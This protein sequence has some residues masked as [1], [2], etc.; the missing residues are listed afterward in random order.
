MKTQGVHMARTHRYPSYM[1]CV[2]DALS[3]SSQPVSI[4]GL[5]AAV[6][7]QRPLG[8]GAH[9]AVK[10]AIHQLFQVIPVGA[11]RY[12]WLSHLLNGAVI[13]HTLAH[14][15][16]LRGFILLDE[17]EHTALFPQFFQ[18]DQPNRRVLTIDLFGGPEI[19]A[20]MSNERKTWSLN[21]G[22]EFTAWLDA[23]GAQ[24]KDDLLFSVVDA[25]SG[26][27]QLRL[28]LH[29]MRDEPLIRDRNIRLALVAEEIVE[30]S[31]TEEH[32]NLA[33]MP[34]W[35]LAARLIGRGLYNESP[36]PDSFH[37][38]MHEYS[39]LHLRNGVNYVLMPADKPHDR[40]Q[41]RFALTLTRDQRRDKSDNGFERDSFA[42]PEWRE[43]AVKR[44][45]FDADPEQFAPD[46]QCETYQAYLEAFYA[47]Q[48][49]GV[50]VSHED[51]HL[52]EA[53][54]EGL[55]NL[56]QDFGRLLAEQQARLEYL[57]ALLFIDPDEFLTGD[58][59]WT[60]GPDGN[61][62]QFWTN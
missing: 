5:L 14:D 24:D 54:L 53:E 19:Q 31:V 56:E 51:F 34:A 58:W 49:G 2:A 32:G 41:R 16:I 52:L 12:G 26:R 8:K 42:A 39:L 48:P 27:Y 1:A 43:R 45:D 37:H 36:P 61:G 50:P 30:E 4:D 25:D 13:R 18:T 38:V 17:L 3:K 29:E 33:A 59:D 47:E 40:D 57:A 60:D 9:T 10:K 6:A 35:N 55:V 23:S 11:G 7:D 28:N 62:P 22:T 44:T 21:L 46:D 15:E 20:E